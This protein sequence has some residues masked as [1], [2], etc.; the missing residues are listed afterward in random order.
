MTPKAYPLLPAPEDP[1]TADLRPRT[2]AQTVV[3]MGR[4]IDMAP[5]ILTH[6]AVFSFFFRVEQDP[7]STAGDGDDAGFP[8]TTL[9][10]AT[11]TLPVPGR[12][13]RPTKTSIPTLASHIHDA[14]FARLAS[15]PDPYSSMGLPSLNSLGTI[16]GSWEGRFSFFD[17]D[18]YRDMLGGRMR[19]LYEGPFGDQPQV[20][21]V[22]ERVVKLKDGREGSTGEYKGGRGPRLNAGFEVGNNGPRSSSVSSSTG[23][24]T[25]SG[26]AGNAPTTNS[27]PRSA[28]LRRKSNDAMGGGDARDARGIKRARSLKGQDMM[29]MKE[30]DWWEEDERDDDGDYEILLTGS[31]SL[32]HIQS[33][34]PPSL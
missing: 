18:S 14:D 19:S 33:H 23:S 2:L 20:W 5:P 3:H 17:F 30:G 13:S 10:T 16:A 12:Q 9:N 29:S 31:V 15:C 27:V 6:A 21:R 7:N 1:F 34:F 26:P 8:G 32:P 22:E 28:G 25:P 24:P 11:L 4:S